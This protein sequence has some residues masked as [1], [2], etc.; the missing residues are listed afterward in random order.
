MNELQI[1]ICEENIQ[2]FQA[3]LYKVRDEERRR[4]IIKLLEEERDILRTFTQT[5]ADKHTAKPTH[6]HS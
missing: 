6:S 4:V 2:R 3:Q 1:W 5:Q